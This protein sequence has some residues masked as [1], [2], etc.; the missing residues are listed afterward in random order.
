MIGLKLNEST[1]QTIPVEVN[2][3]MDARKYLFIS[4]YFHL[5]TIYIPVFISKQQKCENDSLC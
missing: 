4:F 5:N 1:K 3:S 2:S